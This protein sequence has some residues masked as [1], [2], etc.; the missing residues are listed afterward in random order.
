M[1][2]DRHGAETQ[3]EPHPRTLSYSDIIENTSQK[4]FER[5]Q[6]GDPDFLGKLSSTPI[7]ELNFGDAADVPLCST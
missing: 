5:R 2:G 6:M 7:T 3:E 1:A 4:G